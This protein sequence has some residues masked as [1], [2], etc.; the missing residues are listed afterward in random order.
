MDR[1]PVEDNP[2]TRFIFGMGVIL[3]M[4]LGGGIGGALLG[5]VDAPF[6]T[7]AGV[8]LGALVVFVAVSLLYGRYDDN[9]QTV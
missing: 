6:A 8:L 4:F 1:N 2:V 9:I 5:R 7:P 3:A